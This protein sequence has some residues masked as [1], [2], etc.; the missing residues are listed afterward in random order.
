MAKQLDGLGN[1]CTTLAHGAT[2]APY[3]PDAIF[4]AFSVLAIALALVDELSKLGT[5]IFILDFERRETSHHVVS[6]SQ[7]EPDE[8]GGK[9]R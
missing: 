9:R 6:M 8:P 4:P 1:S 2:I 7:Q 3:A 5:S